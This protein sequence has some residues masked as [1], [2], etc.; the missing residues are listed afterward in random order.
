MKRV[1]SE[2]LSTRYIQQ[3]AAVI[4]EST[5]SNVKRTHDEVANGDN[6]DKAD[7]KKLKT[8]SLSNV[9]ELHPVKPSKKMHAILLSYC[10][11]GYYGMQRYVPFVIIFIVTYTFSY[12]KL[13]FLLLTSIFSNTVD[14][15]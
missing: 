13:A 6:D 12:F 7:N 9:S 11:K 5:D 1:V 10:G 4:D 15:V 14:N 8:G 3:M 2:S